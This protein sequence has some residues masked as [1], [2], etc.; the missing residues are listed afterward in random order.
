MFDVMSIFSSE[1]GP[2]AVTPADNSSISVH[3]PL[4]THQEEGC[5]A[6]GASGA[7]VP[8]E[9]GALSLINKTKENTPLREPEYL[10]DDET[11][12]HER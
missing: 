4:F 12:T 9:L 1:I 10:R 3:L 7:R 6:S 8:C 5:G 2:D 11:Q